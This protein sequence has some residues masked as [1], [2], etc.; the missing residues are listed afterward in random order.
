MITDKMNLKAV[1]RKSISVSQ[2]ELIKTELFQ[3]EQLLPFDSTGCRGEIRQLGQ[4]PRVDWHSITEARRAFPKLNVNGAAEFEQFI[5]AI[6]GE[7]IEY[8]Y[9]STPR[10]QVS[11]NIIHQL[12]IQLINRFLYTMKWPI[13]IFLLCKGTGRRDTDCRQSESL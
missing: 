13:K 9:R 5:Q 6:S 12:N 2:Q 7:L 8:S 3:P 11:G 4:P 10:S 1:R